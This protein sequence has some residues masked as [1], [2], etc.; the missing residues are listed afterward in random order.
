MN[1]NTKLA[2]LKRLQVKIDAIRQELEFSLPGQLLF[3]ATPDA[4]S[5]DMVIV[6]A[7]GFGGA[8][9]SVVEGNYPLDYVTKLERS[10]PKENEAVTAAEELSFQGASASQILGSPA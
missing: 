2:K 6:E 7:D 10:F 5:A 1:T 4:I 8:T 9:T 3:L